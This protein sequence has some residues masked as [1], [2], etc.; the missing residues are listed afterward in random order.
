MRTQGGI[1]GVGMRKPRIN[2]DWTEA[3]AKVEREGCCRSCGH[4]QVLEAAHVLGREYD[5]K[6]PLRPT[7][8]WRPF[9]VAPDRIIPLCNACHQGP[10][11]QHAKRLDTLPLLTE[12]EQAQAVVD[13]GGIYPA[14]TLL[15][16]SE[17]PKRVTS[18]IGQ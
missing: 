14:L 8:R 5:D 6:K 11:G 1:S 13:A 12:I 7:S 4:D 15:M 17:N 18:G 3:R 10:N 16:P 2:R 9:H